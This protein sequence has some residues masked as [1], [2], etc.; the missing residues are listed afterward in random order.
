MI[1]PMDLVLGGLVPLVAA[2]LAFT[3]AWFATRRAGAAGRAAAAWNAG[4]VVGFAAGAL[5]L[6]ARG[7]DGVDWAAFTSAASRLVRPVES[8][9]W[10]PLIGLA[11]AVPAL[12]AALARRGWVEW[13]LAVPVCV[14]APARLLWSKYR[15]SQQLRDAGFATDAITPVG[16]ALILSAIAAGALIALALWRRAEGPSPSVGPALPDGPSLSDGPA[17]PKTRSLLAIVAL[18]GAAAVVALTGSL[19]LGQACGV[20]AASI[21]GCAASAWPLGVKAGPESA[22]GPALLL[23]GSLLAAAVC[24]SDLHVWQA[25]L[26]AAA[27][28][29]PVA[30]LP[31]IARFRPLAQGALRTSICVLPLALVT[32]RAAAEFIAEESMSEDS[33]SY[34]DVYNDYQNLPQP[35]QASPPTSP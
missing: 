20:L 16:A 21:G 34:G 29:L 6:N 24:Y 2:A 22:R 5:G 30:W 9:D 10:L 35:R 27:F 28:V 3:A 19:V 17:L 14:A 33:D 25:A 12:A 1:T 32:W 23:A 26:L 7:A 18:T 15:A 4:V 13:L 8:Q 31:G 11:A